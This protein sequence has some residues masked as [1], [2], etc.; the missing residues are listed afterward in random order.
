[1]AT[2]PEV[3][4]GILAFSSK[5]SLA[6]FPKLHH[7]LPHHLSQF[8]I[9]LVLL[10]TVYVVDVYLI[11][12]PARGIAVDE[13][14]PT[15]NPLTTRRPAFKFKN[16]SLSEP[17][18]SSF[19]STAAT[20]PKKPTRFKRST[21]HFNIFSFNPTTKP[22][23]NRNS[24]EKIRGNSNEFEFGTRLLVSTRLPSAA[25]SKNYESE[26]ASGVESE[27]TDQ[28]GLCLF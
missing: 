26:A 2:S 20:F 8:Q 18:M 11:K 3:L 22:K 14:N 10:F 6:K 15:L 28:E 5:I 19:T 16:M 1:M 17:N 24:Y 7:Q 9:A 23:R 25:V 12:C 4:L 13:L 21:S 27:L